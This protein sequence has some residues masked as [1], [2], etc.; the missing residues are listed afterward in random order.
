MKKYLLMFAT[1]IMAT[2]MVSCTETN[3]PPGPPKPP[4]AGE[5]EFTE[6]SEAVYYGEAKGLGSGFYSFILS[7]GQGDKMRINCFGTVA[8]S[9][10]NAKL[11]AGTYKKGSLDEH[12]VRTFV[13]AAADADTSG[14]IYWKNDVA[15]LIT[16]GT[17][18][19]APDGGNTKITFDLK[20][21]E[22]AIKGR[23]SNVIKFDNQATQPPH[24]KEVIVATQLLGNYY[25][26]FG[27]P[28]AK[29]GMF[30]LMLMAEGDA[31]TG[32]NARGIQ[33]QGFMPLATNNQQAF[34]EEGTYTIKSKST[35]AFSLTTGVLDKGQAVG[36]AEYV[37][38]ANSRYLYGW[39]M[40]E[41]TMTV[42][43][44]GDN[45]KITVDMKGKRTDRTSVIGKKLEEIRFSYEGPANALA[46]LADPRSSLK[47]DKDVGTITNQALLQVIPLKNNPK[48]TAWFYYVWGDGLKATIEGNKINVDGDG[49]MMVIALYGPNQPTDLPVGEFP[50]GAYFGQYYSDANW[51]MPGNPV[52]FTALGPDQG[53]W[54][55]YQTHIKGELYY[56]PIAGAMPERGKIV[57]SN[58]GNIHKMTFE[59]YNRFGNSITGGYEGEVIVIKGTPA[60][61]QMST[62]AYTPYVAVDT[63]LAYAPLQV[64][65]K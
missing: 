61:A 39:V 27:D 21:G 52:D 54:Y 6:V 16:D 29:S 34:I 23:F 56:T 7:N 55:V 38:D 44:V 59:F 53:T 8:A 51:T 40:E 37:N 20:A 9:A 22:T 57:T 42:E 31:E 30:L 10:T 5:I 45:Y 50:M 62:R 3:P 15:S 11:A 58:E 25:G 1:A 4:P 49:D 17:F 13:V 35:D 18:T 36:T 28:E 14:T 24:E 65:R 46:N 12:A 60:S 32:A 41:G 26:K 47:E 63:E 2:V 19:V 64:V 33:I 43:I 48:L